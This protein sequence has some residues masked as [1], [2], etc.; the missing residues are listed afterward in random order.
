MEGRGGREGREGREGK[1]KEGKESW[2][3]AFH[4]GQTHG[5][6][7]M[8]YMNKV[9]CC[10]SCFVVVVALLWW[11]WWFVVGVRMVRVAGDCGR[12]SVCWSVL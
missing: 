3:N 11:W 7:D 6:N 12:L 8:N 5:V 10:C 9:I 2:A 1:G 4:L